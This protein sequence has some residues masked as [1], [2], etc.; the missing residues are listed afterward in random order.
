M[1]VIIT[2][3]ARNDL[4]DF[5]TIS[6]TDTEN[7]VINYINELIDCTDFISTSPNIGK[8]VDYINQYTIRQLLHKKHKILYTISNNKIYILR[9]IHTSRNFNL[10]NDLNLVEFL[11]F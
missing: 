6:R 7:Y 5:F 4:Y 2:K 9:F 8:V 3:K 1:E 10:K 11:D